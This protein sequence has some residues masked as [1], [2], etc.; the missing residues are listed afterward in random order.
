MKRGTQYSRNKISFYQPH[1]KI[2]SLTV[3][4]WFYIQHLLPLT[5]LWLLDEGR[6]ISGK[7]F[8]LK[9]NL[10]IFFHSLIPHLY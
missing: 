10:R 4:K 1:Y 9:F 8:F 3:W 6:S 2:I 7:T 5:R